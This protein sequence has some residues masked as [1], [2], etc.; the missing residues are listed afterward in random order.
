MNVFHRAQQIAALPSEQQV[1]LMRRAARMV[2]KRSIRG[3]VRG[4]FYAYNVG[5]SPA[6]VRAMREEG[7]G[8]IIFSGKGYNSRRWYFPLEILECAVDMISSA[9]GRLCLHAET[10]SGVTA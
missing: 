2:E 1:V 3:D 10:A 4:R 6:V 7:H 5:L 8:E 9:H